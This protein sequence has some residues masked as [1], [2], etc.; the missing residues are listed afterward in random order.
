MSDRSNSPATVNE[1]RVAAMDLLARREHARGELQTK[2]QRRFADVE[3]IAGVLDDLAA[4]NLQSDARYAES[5]LRQRLDRGYGP[6]RIQQE[7]RERGV[8]PVRVAAAL[9]AVAP[10]WR[11]AAEQVY[12]RKFDPVP[13]SPAEAPDDP[14]S[15]QA[16]RAEQQQRLKE[17][18]RRMRFMQY[19]GF[20]PEHF[21]HLLED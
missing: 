10:N 6:V 7:M 9:E 18:A 21:R 4:E 8:D 1:V 2:L 15:W 20:L 19:R 17:K 12:A 5:L 14:V 16:R 13:E 11:A 3:L